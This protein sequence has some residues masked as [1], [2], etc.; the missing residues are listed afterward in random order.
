MY[1]YLWKLNVNQIIIYS[2]DNYMKI[3]DFGSGS[4]S[5]KAGNTDGCFQ[6]ILEVSFFDQNRTPTV[7]ALERA[8]HC[9]AWHI[10]MNVIQN[11][12]SHSH[13]LGPWNGI[14]SV[15]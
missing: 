9:D 1:P 6:K 11:G 8:C 4:R 15:C 7:G 3:V 14:A 2:S 12:M 5:V 10:N 13:S